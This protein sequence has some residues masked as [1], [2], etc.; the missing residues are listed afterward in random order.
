MP[1]KEYDTGFYMSTFKLSLLFFKSTEF[2][3]QKYVI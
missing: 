1:K 2:S 3:F